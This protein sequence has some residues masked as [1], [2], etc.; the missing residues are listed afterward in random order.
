MTN[1]ASH[2]LRR[3]KRRRSWIKRRPATATRR[4]VLSVGVI[5]C[6]L[7]CAALIAAMANQL[8]L[9][10]RAMH[11]R[12]PEIQASR[13]AIAGIEIAK[14]R[15]RVDQSYKGETWTIPA[16]P[17][18]RTATPPISAKVVIERDETKITSTALLIRETGRNVTSIKKYTLN[19]S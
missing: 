1:E 13:L 8:M 6:F 12:Q 17:S 16:F 5:L 14:N 4:G 9:A 3:P 19:K 18:A 2:R 7:V 11:L 10:R 15:M